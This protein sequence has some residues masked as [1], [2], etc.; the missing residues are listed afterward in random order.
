MT[1]LTRPDQINVYRLMTL[2][3]ALKLESIGMK[4]SHGRS[5]NSI[6]CAELGLPKGT[7]IATTLAA[8]NA[9]IDMLTVG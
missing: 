8:L 6:V 5:T 1:A 3:S 4:R 9:H 2:R 7:K